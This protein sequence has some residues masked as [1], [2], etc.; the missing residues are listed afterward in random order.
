MR[1]FTAHGMNAT[2]GWSLVRP[3][4]ISARNSRARYV[5]APCAHA[6]F[7]AADVATP[8]VTELARRVL[9]LSSGTAP[10]G[11]PL[12]TGDV[13]PFAMQDLGST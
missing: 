5:T 6:L 9:A 4:R 11:G 1:Q 2:P 13:S 3:L 8:V 12:T 7:A 10:A